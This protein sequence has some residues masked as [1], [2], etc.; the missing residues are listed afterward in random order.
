MGNKMAEESHIPTKGVRPLSL[1][2]CSP[3][4]DIMY[5]ARKNKTDITVGIPN[6]PFRI[7]APSGAP[8]KKKIRQAKERVNFL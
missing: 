3:D 4:I 8:I 6:P 2:I 5:Q 1:A 7:I